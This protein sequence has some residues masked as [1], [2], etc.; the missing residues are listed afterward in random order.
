MDEYLI[1]GDIVMKLVDGI[2]YC[3]EFFLGN[4]VIEFNKRKVFYDKINVI[5]FLLFMLDKNCSN[6]G[7]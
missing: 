7:I 1:F 2:Y 5:W 4:C 3:N 6:G